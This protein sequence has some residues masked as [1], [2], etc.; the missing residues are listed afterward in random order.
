MPMP[1][2][3]AN[4][5]RGM[6]IINEETLVKTKHDHSPLRPHRTAH[7][8][9]GSW[10]FRI[11]LAVA[12]LIGGLAAP[13]DRAK[14]QAGPT[15]PQENLG[16]EVIVTAQET[17]TL[18]LPVI[19]DTEIGPQ[20]DVPWG[21]ESTLYVY[22]GNSSS[23]VWWSLFQFDL[24][25]IPPGAQ[26]LSA[27]MR[28][29]PTFTD[30]IPLSVHRVTKA[31][32]AQVD[33]WSTLSTFH[34]S[35]PAALFIPFKANTPVLADVTWLV[36]QWQSGA[37]PNFGV[38]LK[39]T[40]GNGESRFASMETADKYQHPYLDVTVQSQALGTVADDF[41]PAT[42]FTGNDGLANW[43]GPWQEL[44]ESDGASAGFVKAITRTECV[45][46]ACLSIL[47]D[48]KNMTGKGIQRAVDLSSVN[49]ATLNFDLRRAG[50]DGSVAL[51]IS[52]NAGISWT[53]LAVYAFTTTDSGLAPQT[54]DISAYATAETQVRFVGN[55]VAKHN[56]TGIFIDNVRVDYLSQVIGGRVWHDVNRNSLQDDQEAGLAGVRIELRAGVCGL[57][58][59]P[60][61]ATTFTDDQGNYLFGI[62]QP[63]DYCINQD[64][65]SLPPGF[66]PTG[67]AHPPLDIH[68][69]GTVILDANL[70]FALMDGVKQ[71]SVG[72]YAP[73]TDITWLEAYALAHNTRFYE[74]DFNTCIFTLTGATQDVADL[75]AAVEGEEQTI[76]DEY[77]IWVTGLYVPNDPDYNNSSL[78]YGPQLMNAPQT[79]DTTLGDAGVI[80]AVLD[81]GIDRNHPEFAGRL[82][83]GWDFANKDN[84]PSDDNGHGTN[85]AGI[86]AAGINNGIGAAGVA[87][88]VTIM[89]VKVLNDG[90]SGWWSDVSAGITYAVDNGAKVINLS[91]GGTSGSNSMQTAIA[92][93]V[94][95]GVTVVAAGGN[96]GNTV[97]FYPAS[98]VNSL[99]VGAVDS[100]STR[101]SFSNYGD[102]ID[103]MAPGVLIYNT[104]W[105]AA[106]GSS[107]IYF[108]GTSMAAPHVS[109]AAALMYSINPNITPDEVRTRLY[110]TATDLGTPGL[111]TYY[112][113]GLINIGAAVQGLQATVLV[114]PT[115][116]MQS[117]LTVDVDGNGLADSGDTL[118]FLVTVANANASP[119]AGVVVS[120]TLPAD[121]TY[122]SA[123]S[124]INGIPVLDNSA[125]ATVFPW[126]AGGITLGN[127]P[128][129]G[130]TGVSFDVQVGT[131][132]AGVYAVTAT[133]TVKTATETVALTKTTQVAGALL[134]MGVDKSTSAAGETLAYTVTSTYAGGD[135]L[136]NVG[137]TTAIP[138]GTAYVP[139]SANAGGAVGGGVLSWNL[140][141][142]LAGV[143]AYQAS[144][145]ETV[146]V[147]SITTGGTNAISASVAHTTTGGNRLMLVGLSID[148]ASGTEPVW[149]TSIT[150]A[151]QALTKVGEQESSGKIRTAIWAL[152]APPVGAGNVAVTFNRDPSAGAV[153][154][155]ATFTGVNQTTPY[156]LFTSTAVKALSISIG[157]PSATGELVFDVVTYRG[158]PSMTQGTGQTLRWMD[159]LPISG[160][161]K[162]SGGASTKV[163]TTSSVS[164]SWTGNTND[165]WALAALSIKPATRPS[166]GSTAVAAPTLVQ[167]GSLITVSMTVTAAQNMTN[168]SPAPLVLT[169]TNGISATLVSGPA[170]ASAT[171]GPAGTR[172]TWVYRATTGT[173]TGRLTFGAT[174]TDGWLSWPQAQ[175]NSVIVHPPLVFRA[176]VN[177]P[178]TA[179]QIQATATISDSGN[180]LLARNANRVTTNLAA[181]IGDFVWNDANGDGL[182]DAGEAGIPAITV[183]LT[184]STGQ[185]VSR[186]TDATGHYLFTPMQPGVYTVTLDTASVPADYTLV[187]TGYPI[188]VVLGVGQAVQNADVGLKGR[189]ISVG[190]RI[191]YDSN[192]NGIQDTGEPE[193]GNIS[194]D[195]YFDDG[196]GLFNPGKDY[197]ADSTV[198]NS[199][200]AYR[201]D[202]PAAGNYFVDITDDY[203]LLAALSHTVGSQSQSEPTPMITLSAGQIQLG[204]DFGYVRLPTP[205]TAMIG[206]L[207]WADVNN[208][209]LR[210][211]DEAILSQVQVCAVSLGGGAPIC[212]QTD[213]NG[214]YLLEVPLGVYNVSPP[215]PPLGL[216]PTGTLPK[217]INALY[218]GQH[219]DADFGY[220]AAAQASAGLGGQIWQ[221]LPVDELY[222]GMFDA[223]LE[224]GIPNVSVNVIYDT[225]GNGVWDDAEPYVA[226]I[227]S[228][229]GLYLFDKLLAGPYLVRVVD[230]LRVLRYFAPTVAGVGGS[231][232]T[233]NRAQPYAVT[234]IPGQIDT[235]GDF[236]YR[237]YDAI[238]T[239]TQANAGVIGDLIF[240]DANGDGVYRQGDGDRGIPGVTVA[241]FQNG[242]PVAAT[243]SGINGSYLFT[244]LAP[245]SYAVDVT[246]QFGVLAG[247]AATTGPQAGQD[248][249]SQAHPYSL[250]LGLNPTNLTADFGYM[251]L[252]TI[253]DRIWWDADG[254]GLQSAGEPGL[255]GVPLALRNGADTLI[256]TTTSDADGRYLFT[257]LL[258]VSYTVAVSDSVF[259]PGGLL[260]GWSFSPQYVGAE[261]L[262]SDGNSATRRATVMPGV[263]EQVN[264][265]DFGFTLS[266]EI[267]VG[268][269]RPG[270]V[271]VGEIFQL[272]IILTNTGRTWLSK[273][274]V[275]LAFDP[276]YLAV[277][278][279]TP[280]PDS[281]G[282]DGL[283]VWND[284]LAG[285]GLAGLAATAAGELGP[286]MSTD[287]VVTL[288]GA[289]D[290][291]FLPG[292]AV[293]YT[294]TLLGGTGDPDGSG[295]SLTG[296]PLLPQT[297]STG[298]VGV[299]NPTGVDVVDAG[300]QAT[301][302][303]VYLTWRT[304][305]ESRVAG[306]HVWRR[307]G[308]QAP[309]RITTTP[310]AAQVGGQPTGMAYIFTDPAL[311]DGMGLYELEILLIDGTSDR[312]S[313]GIT[314]RS[315]LI[316]LP[317]MDR[318]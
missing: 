273:L 290:S 175:S 37:A 177:D 92:Y 118:R 44:G 113:N 179:T 51:E 167:S 140:G 62:D 58:S 307:V 221:D 103:L 135:L 97:P 186:I 90:N 143:P 8:S 310:M 157:M 128:A 82:L 258:P 151:G 247:H 164:L 68:N 298:G 284:G 246:D 217:V 218:T 23:S 22:Q 283:M 156:G 223:G 145:V 203:N 127:V 215:Q 249:Q 286:G 168:V 149:A 311:P 147:S 155:V 141:S 304:V 132:P 240:L 201:L 28:L 281:N 266:T 219:L 170:P 288:R 312:I 226:N 80:L 142:N 171:V 72:T 84:D 48:K 153:I 209:R 189:S 237:E 16:G 146:S 105:T 241:L 214:R 234:L 120:A 195:L 66:G 216:T 35:I 122:L 54:F 7:N 73:C 263:G 86:A 116:T 114:P 36:R 210:E 296:L 187:S 235:T 231:S 172:F 163:G 245:G 87:G 204:V 199:A 71:I 251:R 188:P 239:G 279:V 269:D 313:L 126:D 67:T 176:L 297:I 121:T 173:Q 314:G 41:D 131:P 162:S 154:G 278:T 212:T 65:A 257:G 100:T 12:L 1:M 64:P 309:Q 315:H 243:T 182:Q 159:S 95:K 60:P 89:P 267:G 200:G 50:T 106:G 299:V 104:Y 123:S 274:P 252:V 306:F 101:W 287:L 206:D 56:G 192:A 98:Y 272:R 136:Q 13:T 197:R 183:L 2:P 85:V 111:D 265:V 74:K 129:N 33:H 117:I 180:L 294:L 91:L 211:P 262:D 102:N 119:L 125:P 42:G 275:H 40:L 276:A 228:V 282:A 166:R 15:S 150:Y 184:H 220:R 174:A 69:P 233:T 47:S 317:M 318:P 43:T 20:Q 52:S 205:A 280:T 178:P 27:R 112:A 4:R 169:G 10:I 292:S 94:S 256:A 34:A 11:A 59:G 26:I 76:F 133:A 291:T 31:W 55:G 248:N 137:I 295:G 160:A 49:H 139:S 255:P 305:D 158:E 21:N 78:V 261:V 57:V 53:Q 46:S 202:A 227:T 88:R 230:T 303:G 5:I 260:A 109:G 32:D 61:Q 124:R 225:N 77:D 138:A 190:D 96:N 130:Q 39:A 99:A 236:G 293:P 148:Y 302:D 194:L 3:F 193:L 9:V 38:L 254:N 25:A 244:D 300:V 24:S 222:D 264:Q 29:Y 17:Y 83:P 270:V 238:G 285:A 198:S 224:P 271:R 45:N 208:N 185:T 144:S 196:D 115:T 63:G 93:A 30:V 108:S 250:F 81:T 134:R 161:D 110:D 289:E 19:Q 207:V 232:G 14:A 242:T 213:S 79:W 308:E 6:M 191:W 107:Y 181:S 268:I 253:G 152:I 259:L 229:D 70:G 316:F 277:V 18:R 75:R 165:E 301:P